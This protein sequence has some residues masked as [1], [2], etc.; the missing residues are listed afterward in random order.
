M[1]NKK[2]LL[3]GGITISLFIGILSIFTRYIAKN[4]TIDQNV[5]YALTVDNVL[6]NSIPAKGSYHVDVDCSNA[7]AKWDYANWELDIDNVRGNVSC[8]LN[9]ETISSQPFSTYIKNL[10]GTTQGNG[11]FV[12]EKDTTENP[13]YTNAVP[14]TEYGTL[15]SYISVND[16]FENSGTSASGV[17]SFD[18]ST[19]KWTAD[20]SK[21]QSLANWKF[22][23]FKHE[24]TE[25][26]YY[27]VCYDFG[28]STKTGNRLWIYSGESAVLESLRASTSTTQSNCIGLGW[29]ESGS[30]IKLVHAPQTPAASL[31][32][33]FR[34]VSS[35]D[36]ESLEVEADYRYE[37]KNPNNYVWFNDEL[38]RIIGVFD[39]KSH[40]QSGK[41][42][43]KLIRGNSLNAIVYA[44]NGSNSW[45][46]ASLNSILNTTFY[47]RTVNNTC[48]VYVSGTNS[49]N[50]ICDFSGIGLTDYYKNLIATAKW[51]SSGSASSTVSTGI[52]YNAERNGTLYNSNVGLMYAS[53]YGFSVLASDCPRSRGLNLY[54]TDNCMGKS[55][56][57]GYNWTMSTNSSN[58]SYAYQTDYN[59][60][61][62]A[63]SV[64][65]SAQVK[66]VV[67]LDS[68]V[69][70]IDGDGS[71]SNP[72][73]IGK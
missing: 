53:D 67:Y 58:T 73:I 7:T 52:M 4:D 43:V 12:H 40:G 24:I 32:Y 70:Y 21:L 18:S 5:T 49:I 62:V 30:Y 34:K 45:S 28:S 61:I 60:A 14:I 56:L 2:V 47:N 51:Y 10:A 39:E 25:S 55:W 3:L 13:N 38:W 6:T 26:A 9:F 68:A 11:K 69:N 27:E 71:A 15:T 33:D 23:H 17:V 50:S 54:N 22:M 42:L 72:Y 36:I 59:G 20:T 48:A 64:Q 1:N 29:V 65:K 35:S 37:G 16:A 31:S 44:S 46:G 66:P 8:K 19:K 41:D 57:S 63:S